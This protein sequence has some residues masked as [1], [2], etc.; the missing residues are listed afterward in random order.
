MGEKTPPHTKHGLSDCW[1]A[2]REGRG[3]GDEPWGLMA[4]LCF[5]FF[6]SRSL[7]SHRLYCWVEDRKVIAAGIA[8]F[9][10]RLVYFLFSKSSGNFLLL[11]NLNNSI[12]RPCFIS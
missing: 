1:H 4:L 3:A 11:C 12:V 6:F 2:W 7:P 9:S 5:F 10:C 8:V